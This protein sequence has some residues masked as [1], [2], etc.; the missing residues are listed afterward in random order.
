ML[1]YGHWRVAGHFG[2]LVDMIAFIEHFADETAASRTP[3]DVM[4]DAQFSANLLHRLSNRLSNIVYPA[5]HL[6]LWHIP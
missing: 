1:V 6:A 3:G 5:I 4:S 2:N